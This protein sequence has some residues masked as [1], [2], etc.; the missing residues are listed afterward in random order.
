[1]GKVF[2]LVVLCIVVILGL[3]FS[4][5]QKS[6][7]SSRRIAP[8]E[9]MTVR[10]CPDCNLIF[11]SF[12]T[13]RAA[14]VSALGY[15][16]KT[17]PN[18][19]RFAQK[20]F[21]FENAVT[22]SPWTLPTS[23]SWFTGVYPSQHKVINKFAI[24][25]SKE[26]IANLENLAPNL[27][28]LAQVLRQN[29]FRT[30]AFTG[31]AGVNHQFGFNKGF[32]I[33]TD[34]HDFAGF[35]E[36]IPLALNWIKEHQNE[37]L[38]VFLHG[39]DIHGQYVPKDGYD[40]R[41]V[42]FDYKGQLTGSKEEQKELRE[43]GLAW[44][45]VFLT[46]EDVR[47]LIA[48]YDE[49]IQRADAKFAQFVEEYQKLGLLDKTI[50]VLTADHGEEFY[51]HGGIDHGRT[52]YDEVIRVPLIISLPDIKKGQKID[53][54]VA[55]IDLM[56]TIFDLLEINPEESVRKQMTGISLLPF[57]EGAGSVVDVYPETDYR[58]AT[59]QRA[60][61]SSD[62]WKLIF[63]IQTG[64]KE[65][66]NLIKD[67]QEKNMVDKKTDEVK[68]LEKKL[69]EYLHNN[70]QKEEFDPGILSPE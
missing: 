16:R 58:Y 18:L 7:N 8:K 38:F 14:N 44:G 66:Y 48:L 55:S 27:K 23:M 15:K 22:V 45:Q 47:F 37:K 17:T 35:E 13:L 4:L 28:T 36:T 20:A 43:Q 52:L 53:D 5:N 51:E 70:F 46:K 32:E 49:K 31:G 67:P 62:G 19:D 50:F 41:F 33:Y 61:R 2:K 24:T 65:S 57:M 12:D 26:E 11:V 6:N 60:I 68:K 69:Q 34:N 1:M 39:Y 63:N 40:Y 64:V 59:S 3:I 25:D 10:P 54:Q 9:K 42:D 30:G 21:N 56:P 29:G